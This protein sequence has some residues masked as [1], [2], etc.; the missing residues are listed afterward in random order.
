MRDRVPS[1]AGLPSYP[2]GV[3][4]AA[5]RCATHHRCAR[6]ILEPGPLGG[7]AHKKTPGAHPK[8]PALFVGRV[9]AASNNS[10]THHSQW[11]RLG[12][13]VSTARAYPPP[14]GTRHQPHYR[15]QPLCRHAR[16]GGCAHCNPSRLRT[17]IDPPAPRAISKPT[18][19]DRPP[20]R[21]APP[22]AAGRSQA[23]GRHRLRPR[24][25]QAR[26]RPKIRQAADT[27]AASPPPPLAAA[28]AEG[29]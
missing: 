26:P 14:R 10:L 19:C 8:C 3:G 7:V 27:G 28:H 15:L 11:H 6:A 16:S 9:L 18:P 23:R 24:S 4:H 21:T 1:S 22:D 25:P 17:V 12:A 2:R 29:R 20:P 5:P 13:I